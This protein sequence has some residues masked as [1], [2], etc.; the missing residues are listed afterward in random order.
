MKK[1][2]STVRTLHLYFGLFISP[3]IL[4]FSISVLIFNHPGFINRVNPVKALP[5]IKTKL[6]KIPYD[7]S[8]V[9]TAKAIIKKL[10][11]KGEIDFI[12]RN[13]SSISF[14]VIKP[15]LR[16]YIKV[17]TNTDSVL[18]SQKYEGPLRSM[19]YLHSMPGPH[20]VKLRGNS[21][22][23]K[24]WRILSD[25]AVY[26]LLFLTVSGIFLWYFLKVERVIGL[27]ALSLG[28]LFFVGVL[29]LIFNYA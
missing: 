23:M 7:T 4:I 11:I 3:L 24:A 27:Y 10:N 18:I 2:Y 19:T 22:F 5:D 26:L 9:E 8:D 12:S 25:V 21:G 1:Y 17:N 29:I 20:N 13:D 15:G 28:I 14:P 6:D 16:T